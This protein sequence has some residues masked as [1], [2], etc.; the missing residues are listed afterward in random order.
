MKRAPSSLELATRRFDT[1]RRA[2]GAIRATHRLALA[3]QGGDVDEL[4]R[5]VAVLEAEHASA[6]EAVR[7][8][9]E[10]RRA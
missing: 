1:A 2:L 10:A 5:V 4:A 8:A 3:G 9:I 7:H 6:R